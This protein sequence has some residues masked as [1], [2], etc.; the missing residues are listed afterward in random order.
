[1]N[2]VMNLAQVADYLQMSQASVYHLLADGKIP[3]TKVG[4]QWR[5][6]RTVIDH[7]IQGKGKLASDILV[8]EDDPHIEKVIVLTL[9][10]GGHRCVGTDLVSKAIKMMQEIK[11][12]LIVLDLMLPDG[13]GLDV[14]KKIIQMPSQPQVI[15]VTGNPEHELIDEVR[16]LLPYITI[17][18]KPVRL[19]SLLELT[20]RMI[21]GGST[22]ATIS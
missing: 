21:S 1:M 19:Q 16:S 14:I 17:L 15:M 9:K 4:K 20:S 22:L 8:V 11:F 3:G 10:E 18:N 12:D 2:D 5:F 13:T 6:A 7:W